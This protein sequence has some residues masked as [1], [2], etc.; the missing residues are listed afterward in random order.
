MKE[1]E[2]LR[3]LLSVKIEFL[4]TEEHTETFEKIKSMLS[5]PATLAL[6]NIEKKTKIRTDGSLLNCI[7]V[8]LYQQDDQD[9]IWKPGDCASRFLTET[10]KNYFPIE[11]EML[12]ATWGMTRMN[13]Y[14]QGL[15]HFTLET[16][17]KPLVPILNTKLISD[18]SPRI[19]RM[20]MKMLKFNFTAT[21]VPGKELID[22]DALSET[23]MAI[24]SGTTAHV[25]G[26]MSNL[27]ANNQIIERIMKETN[28]DSIL[29]EVC[30]YIRGGW[31]IAKNQCSGI[32][33]PY[34]EHHSNLTIL[35]GL[36]MLGVRIVIPKNLQADILQKI[37]AGHCG[38]EK[39]KRRA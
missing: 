13:L 39:C 14:L 24:E 38:I 18:L 35:K 5:S 8:V 3:G 7:S 28:K 26:I 4:W 32:V 9:K 30:E 25:N 21:Y 19:Q 37:H 15:Q 33:A 22:A 36:I 23:N 27:P 12:A 16:D 11:L 10:E 17:H 20:R 31:P 34:W 6:Y 1:A 2:P 29:T